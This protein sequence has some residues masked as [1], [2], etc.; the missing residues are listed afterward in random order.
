MSALS[1]RWRQLSTYIDGRTQRERGMLLGV[2]AAVLVAGVQIAVLGPLER[3]GALLRTQVTQSA[4]AAA[5]V[6]DDIARRVADAGKDPNRLVRDKLEATRGDNARMR[7]ALRTVQKGLVPPERI[8]PLLESILRA[9]GR[10]KLVSLKSL[11]VETIDPGK[12]AGKGTGDAGKPPPPASAQ[13][14]V[15]AVAA[16]A[17]AQPAAAAAAAVADAK[18]PG[19]GV[20]LYR[21]GVELTVRGG[22]LDMVDTMTALEGLPSQLFWGRA[23]LD[24]D[25]Y[26]SAQ[27]TLTLYTLSLDPKWMKI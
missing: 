7:D 5:V 27:L 22:Y 24:V 15:D 13:G 12:D 23:Q 14:I 25:A 21:H 6:N 26:P 18:A 3:K 10:L 11:P 17:S 20:V 1:Q 2:A 19:A 4:S 16:H 9:N 8:A